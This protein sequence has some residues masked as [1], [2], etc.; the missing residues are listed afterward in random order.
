MQKLH[1][2]IQWYRPE[3][4]GVQRNMLYRKLFYYISCNFMCHCDVYSVMTLL[5]VGL[6][7]SNS[8]S[9]GKTGVQRH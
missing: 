7:I 1:D 9:N 8:I 3:G 6:Q 4:E 5:F 2:E